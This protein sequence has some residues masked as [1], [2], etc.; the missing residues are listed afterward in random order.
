VAIG[1]GK[2]EEG[3]RRMYS[4]F[5]TSLQFSS[6]VYWYQM[7]PHV[8]LPPMPPPAEREP[9]PDA[10]FWPEQMRSPSESDFRAKGAK[11]VLYCGYPDN[12]LIYTEPG[13]SISW[14]GENEQWDDWDGEVF[15]C[16]HNDREFGFHLN[17]P[18]HVE[19]VLRLYIID[20]DNYMG[21]RKEA[22][23]V[24]GK[25]LG[26]YDHFQGGR[27]IDVPVNSDE[28][29]NGKLSVRIANARNG[30]NAVLSKIEWIENKK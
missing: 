28:I 12:E 6:T 14:E 25:T 29:A 7:D 10:L 17:L 3:W 23:I 1:F 5:G 13:Y 24:D 16:R 8:A 26:T 21:G 19:G 11:F 20:A 27:W 15:Y 2:T 22:I 30:A 9:A 4:K 18:A